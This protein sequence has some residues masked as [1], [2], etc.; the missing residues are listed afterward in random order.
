MAALGARRRRSLPTADGLARRPGGYGP[1]APPA[2]AATLPDAV[3]FKTGVETFAGAHAFA[4]RDGVIYLRPATEGRGVPGTPW[5]VLKMPG[6]L[7]GRVRQISADHRLLLA[8]D[9]TGQ[10]YANDMTGDDV[11]PERWTWRWG[12]I[13]GRTRGR[14]TGYWEKAIDAPRWR[15]VP[16]SGPLAGT[17]VT[18]RSPAESL[19]PDDHRY[20]GTID[21]AAA[22]VRN[23]NA[24]CSPATLRVQ[25]APGLPLDLTLHTSDGLRQETRASGLDDVPREYNGA[26]EVPAATWAALTRS[27]LRLRVWIDTHLGGRRITTAPVALTRTRLRFLAQCWTLTLGGGSARADR[28]ALDAGGAERP[29]AGRGERTGR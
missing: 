15:F 1:V 9:R 27:D 25:V 20:A 21:G 23:L 12:P 29:V 28:P 14:R 24:E 5:R 2:V 3:I 22:E 6:C 4:L 11:A 17:P 10:V 26:I 13:A 8:V 18:R 16:V 19:A 7:D